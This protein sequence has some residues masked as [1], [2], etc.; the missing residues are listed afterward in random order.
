MIF[1][2]GKQGNNREEINMPNKYELMFIVRQDLSSAQV[3]DVTK[4][5]TKILE[6]NGG[7]V[8]KTDIWGLRTLAYKIEKNRKGHY[9][10]LNIETPAEAL[11]EV[12]RLMRLSEDILRYMSVRVEDFFD[13]DEADKDDQKNAA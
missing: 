7:K 9:V 5:F 8:L 10:L 3:E 4:N 2:H 1:R 6:D 13:K 12:E 11:H